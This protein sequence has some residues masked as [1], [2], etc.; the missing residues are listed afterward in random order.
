MLRV[1]SRGDGVKAVQRLL[2]IAADGVFGPGTD[3]AVR[4]FQRSAGLKD[5]G[6]VG[7]AT[8]AALSRGSRT[9]TGGD[10][11]LAAESLGV[12]VASVRAVTHVESRASGFLSDGRPVI[13]F[14]RHIMRRRLAELGRDVDLLQRY[15]PEIINGAPGGYKGGSAEHDRLY[16]AQQIDFD[17]AVESASWGLFQIM[18]FHWQVLGYESAKAFARAMNQS[19]GQQLDAFVRFIKADAG[20]HRALRSKNWADFAARYNGPAYSKNQY[21]VKLAEAYKEF[22]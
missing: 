17:S 11:S 20:L 19:E 21:D 1:G 14:E 7:A 13:L 3:T 10:L 2:G 18:G 22:A 12:D 16:L 5:D 15:L 4:A 9:L 6:V 8:M